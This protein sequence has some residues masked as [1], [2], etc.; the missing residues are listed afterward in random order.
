ML[1][2]GILLLALVLV[3]VRVA[4]RSFRPALVGGLFVEFSFFVEAAGGFHWSGGALAS[5]LFV[6]IVYRES[7]WGWIRFSILLLRLPIAREGGWASLKREALPRYSCFFPHPRAWENSTMWWN[8]NK[9]PPEQNAW[10][11]GLKSSTR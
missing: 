11:V 10:S 2:R 7:M 9:V 8:E 5:L 6:V 1:V 3:M 4:S